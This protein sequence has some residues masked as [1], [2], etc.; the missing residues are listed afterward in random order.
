MR[1][2]HSLY[3]ILTF[4]IGVI[5]LAVFLMG[6]GNLLTNPA[7]SMFINIQSDAVLLTAEALVR[8]GSFLIVNFPLIF[9]IRL[10]T[11][12]SGSATSIISAVSGYVT[13]LAFTM[14][15]TR[16]DLPTTAYS[17]ILGISA[18]S[19]V[20]SSLAG[21]VRYPLQ[22]GVL[23]TV[24]VSL[25]TLNSYSASR[26]STDYGVF[27]FMSKD[28]RCVLRTIV[29]CGLAGIAVSYG[30]PYVIRVISRVIRFIASDTTNPINL[31]LYG[32]M[33][34]FLGVLNLG[35]L[36][37]SPFWY[38]ANGGSWIN[39]TGASIAGDVNI[40]TSQLA[41]GQLSG[42]TGRFITPYYVLNL[43]AMPGL[44]WGLYSIQTDKLERNRMRLYFIAATLMSLFSGTLLPFEITLLLLCPLLFVFHICYTGMLFGVFQSMHVYLGY[45]YAGTSTMVVT[46]GTLME[47]LSYLQ[48]STLTASIIR[49]LI[50][51]VISGI[52]YFMATRFYF[53]Y[54]ALDLFRVG[55]RDRVVKATI[56]AVGGI[57]NVKL[58]HSS[59]S[60][61]IISLYDPSKLNVQKLKEFGS[62]RVYETKAGYAISFGSASTMIRKGI[63]Q[64]LR[65]YVR[66][67][68]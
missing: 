52:I 51:G 13:Y 34:R 35:T 36:I 39:M 1:N 10:V 48:Y 28:V 42:M 30:W 41:T 43:F 44:L 54:L 57:A 45:N 15:F 59:M 6:T 5:M 65:A 18:T 25:I 8:V 19:S 47:L 7:Y 33:D 31:A 9:L 11:R 26:R 66:N 49:I 4:P 40:W 61:L 16:T 63:D 32:M 24:L 37:R 46:P 58:I 2:W 67:V 38:G 12:R 50:V 62:L 17:S 22:T 60:R 21:S 56:E 20:V 27:S 68:K 29:L 64:S 55:D 53:N 23:A 14:Y 3:E